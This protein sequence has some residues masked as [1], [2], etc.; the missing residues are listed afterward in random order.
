[1]ATVTATVA[2]TNPLEKYGGVRIALSA[3]EQM[4]DKMNKGVVPMQANHS[5][6]ELVE[7]RNIKA[8]IEPAEDGEHSLVVDFDIDDEKW[9]AIEDEWKRADAPG[10]FSVAITTP[11][12]RFDGPNEQSIMITADAAAYSDEARAAAG[13]ALSKIANVEVRRL[14]QFSEMELAKIAIELA[15]SIIGGGGGAALYEALA[16]LVK[17]R[18][19]PSVLEF[20]LRRQDGSTIKAVM[21]TSDPLIV[22]KA[23]DGL[24][25]LIDTQTSTHVFDDAQNQWKPRDD[26]ATTDR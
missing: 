1:M 12:M 9:E 24:A 3:L 15:V 13:L 23:I 26:N 5:A 17:S 10:G 20:D 21:K 6:L 19:E 25:K 8:R 14:L 7:A 11:Q 22:E 4:R 2:S 18:N 16:G